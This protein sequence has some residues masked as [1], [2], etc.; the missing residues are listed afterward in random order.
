MR[1]VFAMTLL[2]VSISQ[3]FNVI[4]T[5]TDNNIENI[6]VTGTTPLNQLSQKQAMIGQTQTLSSAELQQTPTRSLAEILRNQLVSVNINDVQNNPFQPDVQYRGF[7]ASPL[8]GLPQGLSIYLNGTR[9]NEP[10]GDTVNWDLLPLEAL[11]NVVLFSTSNPV[12]GQNTLGGALALN[13]K[14]GF[15]Y[16][17]TEF[18]LSFGQHGRQE[19]SVQTGNN[20]GNWGW[21]ALLNQY[22]EDGWR[23]YSPSDVRQLFSTLSYHTDKVQLDMSWLHVSNEL[24]GN[25]AIPEDLPTFES[26]S[27]VYTHPDRTDNDLDFFAVNLNMDLSDSLDLVVNAFYRDNTTSSING[28]DSDYGPCALPN[29]LVTLCELEDEDDDDDDDHDDDI[30]GIGTDD[31]HDD[32][33]DD[34][35]D[36]IVSAD[37]YE[38]VEFVGYDDLAFSQISDVDPA[39]VDGTYNTGQ[40]DNQSYGIT[41]QLSKEHTIG[42]MSATTVVGFGAIEGDINYVADTTFGILENESAEDSRTVTPLVGIMDAEA[43]VRLDV[44]T[45]A[46]F[47]YIANMTQLSP[48]T[49]L[50]LAARFNRDHILMNDLLEDGEGSLD[51]DHLFTSINPA[52]SISHQL[53]DNTL[54]N[55][56]LAQASRV[57]SPAELSCADEDDPCRLPNGFVA[58]PPL[59]KVVTRTLE[60]SLQGQVN[61][62]DYNATV[63]FSQ[64]IDDIIFQQAGST[65]SRGYFINI[66]KTQRIGAELSAQ[67]QFDQVQINAAYNY[68]DATFESGFTSFSPMNPLGPNR[69]VSPGD[70]I[71][72]Q[73]KHQIKL[74]AEYNM[75]DDW[76]VGGQ[77]IYASEQY[78]RGDEANENKTISGYGLVNLYA[79]YDMSDALTLSMR[80]D[81]ALDREYDT[82]GTYGE[83][84]E[85]L[86]DI[87]PEVDSP[88]FIGV[89]HPRTISVNAQYVF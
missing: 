42:N 57:P 65:S 18:D 24:L 80:L 79:T 85:V 75:G 81:N 61:E 41:A 72:G 44:D 59:L 63:F 71:P 73:P 88:Y 40:A 48:A 66:D 27:S 34:D 35:D 23:D 11:E 49:T 45:R 46:T 82:F 54:F 15:N 33:D 87:Y 19:W 52:I 2:S 68:L 9:V 30:V 74:R 84:D 69:E 17:Q 8:L 32:D 10:F 76:L 20:Q 29:D 5:E 13:T 78:Y 26:R 53:D 3:S 47:A 56:S 38:V 22:E 16:T 67:H 58:D 14:T 43:T 31:D 25:G 60:A 1:N 86:E 83:A 6:L 77:F 55:L 64:S 4:A 51:G 70:T 89:G 7:T 37:D 62:T 36:S 28:D 21:Y 50:N 12:F 39:T